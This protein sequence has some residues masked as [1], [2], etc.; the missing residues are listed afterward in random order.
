MLA[1][2]YIMVVS[3]ALLGI[4]S[5]NYVA[6]TMA[7]N[8]EAGYTIVIDAG[9]G[10]PDGGAVSCTG[11]PE[12]RYNLEI[13][14]RLK[15]LLN[16]LGHKTKL[17]RTGASS[18]YTKGNTIA[19]KKI[20]DLKERVQIVENTHNALLI[21]IHQNQFSDSVYSGAVILY[22]KKDGSKYLADSMQTAFVQHLNPGSKRKAKSA[23]GVYLME[24]ISCPAVLVECGFLSNVQEEARL[25]SPEYQKKIC[26]ILASSISKFI[27]QRPLSPDDVL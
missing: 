22:G 4:Y 23:D 11:I 10:E 12:S 1:S 20:S 17:T 25:R 16:L 18:I 8:A 7:E 14:M 6:T 9:H 26:C 21:S 15:D 5:C 2:M 3:I 24:H 27:T 19:E 13:A